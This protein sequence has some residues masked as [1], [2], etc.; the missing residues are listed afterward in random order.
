MREPKPPHMALRRLCKGKGGSLYAGCPDCS[1][2][3]V[4]MRA[5]SLSVWDYIVAWSAESGRR[6]TSNMGDVYWVARQCAGAPVH[7]GVGTRLPSCLQ[8]RT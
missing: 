6:V 3:G 4:F 5:A 8:W 2:L 1:R 7:A